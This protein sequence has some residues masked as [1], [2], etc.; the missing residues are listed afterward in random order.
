MNA[1]SVLELLLIITTNKTLYILSLRP[2][3][4]HIS[5]VITTKEKGRCV[6]ATKTFQKN[7]YLFEYKGELLYRK[8]ALQRY[9]DPTYQEGKSFFYFF[10]YN[11]VRLC[12]DA[13]C[14]IKYRNSLGRLVNHPSKGSKA[15]AREAPTCVANT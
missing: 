4:Q 14:D 15:T 10:T 3:I 11:S 7:Q 12:I 6:Y 8:E 5:K 1:T 9:N 2:F 13:S